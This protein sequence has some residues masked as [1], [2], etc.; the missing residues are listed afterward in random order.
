MRFVQKVS[1]AFSL[2][3]IG[4][5]A[6]GFVTGGMSMDADMETANRLV[7]LFPV[8]VVH[9]AVHL[10]FG[11]WG[12]AAASSARAAKRYCT[13]SGAA[14]LLLT[15]V[16]FVFPDTFGL[17]PIGGHDIALH[18]IFG[19]ILTAVGASADLEATVP[20]AAVSR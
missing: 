2:A 7:G 5:A 19:A 13:I 3:F 1:L 14:Y 6:L 16:G 9:K 18:A 12:M 4:A 10:V 17:I 8:N 15:G 20:K 11:L